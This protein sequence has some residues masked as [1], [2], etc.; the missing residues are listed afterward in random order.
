MKMFEMVQLI[1]MIA[2]GSTLIFGTIAIWVLMGF[3]SARIL[4]SFRGGVLSKGWKYICIAVPFFIIGQLS[5]GMSDSG[6]IASMQQEILAALGTSL[7]AIG[8][9]MV[10]VGFRAQYNAWHPKEIKIASAQD[11]TTTQRVVS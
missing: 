3:Y 2:A 10:V 1:L 9:L 11:T 8:G 6:S 4:R 7:S 5:T